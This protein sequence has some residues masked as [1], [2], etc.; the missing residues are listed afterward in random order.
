[1][2]KKEKDVNETTSTIGRVKFYNAHKGYGFVI[3]DKDAKEYFFHVTG[4]VNHTNTTI[5]N[6]D[7]VTYTLVENKERGKMQAINVEKI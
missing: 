4:I 6:D 3:D 1:M 2:A 5:V 7:R